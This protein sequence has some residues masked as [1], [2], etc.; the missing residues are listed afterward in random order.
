MNLNDLPEYAKSKYG[1]LFHRIRQHA[2]LK[3]SVPEVLAN[4]VKEI[5]KSLIPGAEEFLLN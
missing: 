1:Y 2:H 4:E 3:I 5:L